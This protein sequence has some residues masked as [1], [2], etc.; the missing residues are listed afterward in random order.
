MID[1]FTG[2]ATGLEAPA[3]IDALRGMGAEWLTRAFRAFGSLGGDNA[4]ARIANI[5]ACPGGSTGAPLRPQAAG[6]RATVASRS[7]RIARANTE[8]LPPPPSWGRVGVGEASDRCRAARRGFPLPD[9]PQ[10]G[11]G[12]ETC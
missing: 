6:A 9:L 8:R 7:S 1:A 10:L 2:D 5:E 3:H 11:G 12:A 4:V